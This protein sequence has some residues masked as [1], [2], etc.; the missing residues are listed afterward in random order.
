MVF[1]RSLFIAITK[2][3]C[4]LLLT[5]L[6]S[7]GEEVDEVIK[8]L[9]HSKEVPVSVIEFINSKRPL[10]VTLFYDKIRKIYN[11]KKNKLY[12][13]IVREE[14]KDPKEVLT[15]LASLNL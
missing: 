4:L 13:N 3:D 10:D 5:D 15:T 11:K 14:Q 7:K 2:N 9:L 12:I 8:N 6:K 1:Q